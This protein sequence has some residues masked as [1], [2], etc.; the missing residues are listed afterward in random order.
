M[1]SLTKR[2]TPPGEEELARRNA[3]YQA[4]YRE[5]YPIRNALSRRVYQ[6]GRRVYD[7]YPDQALRVVACRIVNFGLL[8]SLTERLGYP[9][10]R[11]LLPPPQ[12]HSYRGLFSNVRT[13][14]DLSSDI[15][16]FVR[17]QRG[18]TELMKRGEFLPSGVPR[19][20]L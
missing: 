13:V 11:P 7:E 12:L 18:R 6:F 8:Y 3:Q 4:K 1:S 19:Q 16:L 17:H 5:K 20:R 14:H 10:V 15:K 9:H 2:H